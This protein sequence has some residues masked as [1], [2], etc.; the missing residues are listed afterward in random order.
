MFC[1]HFR[2]SWVSSSSFQI[3]TSARSVG[4]PHRNHWR[5]YH[6]FGWH[7]SFE[8]DK[9]QIIS[10]LSSEHGVSHSECGTESK[11]HACAHIQCINT[12][13]RRYGC[14]RAE[15]TAWSTIDF[16]DE[17]LFSAFFLLFHSN[18]G[19]PDTTIVRSFQ[20]QDCY[21][22]QQHI[23]SLYT[24]RIH[25]VSMCGCMNLHETRC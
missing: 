2:F 4:S 5:A 16:G 17:K 24:F 6:C 9:K 23:K 19:E 8:N 20:T 21:K 10:T 11:R 7:I 13:A 14:W 15:K 3:P 1:V 18:D 12:K 25:P 22:Q